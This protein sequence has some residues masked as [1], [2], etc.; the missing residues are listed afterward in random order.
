MPRRR[1]GGSPARPQSFSIASRVRA[2]KAV[3]LISNS[4]SNDL[5]LGRHSQLNDHYREFS[6]YP[7]NQECGR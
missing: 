7:F 6:E 4:I 1:K 5:V 3:P 2:G